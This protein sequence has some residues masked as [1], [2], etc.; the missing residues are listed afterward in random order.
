MALSFVGLMGS[1]VFFPLYFQ[2]V[3]GSSPA[4]PAC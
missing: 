1:S 2:L 3:M 4:I